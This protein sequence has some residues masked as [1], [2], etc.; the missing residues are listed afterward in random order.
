MLEYDDELSATYQYIQELI[1]C[2]HLHQVHRF[3]ELLRKKFPGVSHYT[4]HRCHNLFRR[5]SSIKCGLTFAFF[6]GQTEDFNNRI[7]LIKRIALLL[8]IGT[9]RLLKL[10]FT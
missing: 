4:S 1:H 7:K 10:A 6:N 9:S 5:R 3:L 8:A 2:Y